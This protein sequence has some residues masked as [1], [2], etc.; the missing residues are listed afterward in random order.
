MAVSNMRLSIHSLNAREL[1]DNHVDIQLTVS[2]AD[3]DQ[4]NYLLTNLRKLPGVLRV[5][6]TGL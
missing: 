6:R 5:Q 2:V 4:L 3:L 1:K